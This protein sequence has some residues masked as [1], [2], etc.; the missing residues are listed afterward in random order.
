M[1]VF[2]I[3]VNVPDDKAPEIL[4]SVTDYLGWTSGSGVNR[5]EF[6]R[7]HIAAQLKALY[8]A[9]KSSEAYKAVSDAETA[10]DIVS[11]S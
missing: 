9:A 3:S 2:S 5:Q 4:Q 6:L 1:A 11:F 7:K 8:R 10:A